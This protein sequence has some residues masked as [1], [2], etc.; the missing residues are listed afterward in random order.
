MRARTYYSR[1]DDRHHSRP[2]FQGFTF[3]KPRSSRILKCKEVWPPP[4]PGLQRSQAFADY[5][6]LPAR[7]SPSPRSFR[8]SLLHCHAECDDLTT[9][10]R[11]LSMRLDYVVGREAAARREEGG[12]R[13]RHVK[14][15]ARGAS[16]PFSRL[17][18]MR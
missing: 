3:V 14:A 18:L 16:S 13:A 6:K 15:S 8:R 5:E 12:G 1:R 10:I 7:L 4:P 11:P 9:S 17:L 2:E